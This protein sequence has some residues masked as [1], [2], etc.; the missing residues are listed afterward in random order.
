MNF[1]GSNSR[2]WIGNKI[3]LEV[4][5]L[6]SKWVLLLFPM[7]AAKKYTGETNTFII[8]GS[9]NE[10]ETNIET[11]YLV[12]LINPRNKNQKSPLSPRFWTY[13]WSNKILFSEWPITWHILEP[14]WPWCFSLRPTIRNVFSRRFRFSEI[15]CHL[16]SYLIAFSIYRVTSSNFHVQIFLCPPV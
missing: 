9:K 6:Y 5:D 15:F 4:T 2:S 3:L 14:I 1:L 8:Y 12:W 11:F 10:K 13:I 7:R 16:L